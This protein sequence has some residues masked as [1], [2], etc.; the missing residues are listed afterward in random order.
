MAEPQPGA[1]MRVYMSAGLL[2]CGLTGEQTFGLS[3]VIGAVGVEEGIEAG[4]RE[5]DCGEAIARRP[6]VDL[7][8]LLRH[9]RMA[10]IV[11]QPHRPQAD[12]RMGLAA[13]GGA[14]HVGAV[15]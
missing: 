11:A 5:F 4:D 3:E 8:D 1:P 6:D 9:Q 13:A 2:W 14:G 15:L 12:D 10:E 7:V